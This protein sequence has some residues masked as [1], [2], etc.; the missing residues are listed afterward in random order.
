MITLGICTTATA[1]VIRGDNIKQA[2]ECY[3]N[4]ADEVVVVDGTYTGSTDYKWHNS[5]FF[6]DKLEDYS[7]KFKRTINEW[8]K[9]FNWLLIGEQFTSAYQAATTDWV[10][11][12]D[13]DMIWHEKDY[14]TI[15]EACEK[16]PDAP[17]LSFY[18]WQFILPDRYN[19][20]SRLVLLANKKKY[21]DRLKFNAGGDLAQLSLDDK[22]LTPD[23]VP[24]V[25]VP[26]YNYEKITKT[27]SQIKDD[28][29]RMARAWQRHFGEYRLGGPDDESAYQ[30]WLT[31]VV[32]RFKK[33]QERVSLDQHPLVMQEL[34]RNLKP[35]QWGYNGFNNL[36]ENDYVNSM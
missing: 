28:V 24:Q 31:M 10:L 33:P 22:Y 34:I 23:D 18:K 16:Y 14:Q 20:K 11:R 26:I 32:G 29:G 1:P 27:E 4:L 8:P 2:L 7:P 12:A 36:P 6:D 5:L 17:A 15:R 13:L 19:L 3:K 9:E 21:G 25:G 30:E 35:E